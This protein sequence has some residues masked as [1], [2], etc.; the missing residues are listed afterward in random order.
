MRCL[1]SISLSPMSSW[2]W[3]RC[4]GWSLTTL[5]LHLGIPPAGLEPMDSP[6]YPHLAMLVSHLSGQTRAQLILKGYPRA[7]GPGIVD[8]G[9]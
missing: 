1:D 6:R 2:N 5:Q 7:I 3:I 9:I 4:P 8:N